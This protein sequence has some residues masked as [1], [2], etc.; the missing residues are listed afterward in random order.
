MKSKAVLIAKMLVILMLLF[1]CAFSPGYASEGLTNNIND[2]II[3]TVNKKVITKKTGSVVKS[4]SNNQLTGKE[5]FVKNMYTGQY[6]D[7]SGGVA[8][9]GT[10]VQQYKYNGTDSQRWYIKDNGDS[11]VSLYTRLG[12]SGT[13]VYG[14]DISN[15]S[16]E[17]YANVQIWVINGT[18]AQKFTLTETNYATYVLFTKV[19]NNSKAV[20]LNGPTCDQGRN[21]DQYTFQGHINEAWILEPV[22]KNST[23]SIEYAKANYNSYVSAYPNNDAIGGDCANFTS[24]CMLAAGIHYQNDWS[25]YRKND[26]YSRPTSVSELNNTWELSDPSP[27][28]SAKYFSR[29]WKK[30]SSYHYYKGKDITANPSLAWNLSIVKGDVIQIAGSIMGILGDAEHTMYITGYENSTYLLTYHSTN[31]QSK[32]LLDLCATYP[33]SYFVFYEIM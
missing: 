26:N 22:D 10:N 33:N 14:L 3:V 4:I 32:S 19:S 25:V 30:N 12:N 7:V 18:D 24:Q 11:T 28:I 1:V 13:Y 8:A 27:W 2:N 23:L 21:V 29:Y 5:Y 17:N 20:V 16:G 15:G 6:L 31:T 9:N